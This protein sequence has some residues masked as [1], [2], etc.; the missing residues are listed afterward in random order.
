MR[1]GRGREQAETQAAECVRLC[2]SVGECVTEPAGLCGEDPA[3]GLVRIREKPLKGHR[4]EMTRLAFVKG[5][6][7]AWLPSDSGRCLR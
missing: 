4:R 2:L 5:S 7:R 6:S 3:E 1:S